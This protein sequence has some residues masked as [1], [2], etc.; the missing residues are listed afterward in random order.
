MYSNKRLV[1]SHE[2]NK[3]SYN[4]HK[5]GVFIAHLPFKKTVVHPSTSCSPGF[6]FVPPI[7]LSGIM[8]RPV[9]QS[10]VAGADVDMWLL[11]FWAWVLRYISVRHKYQCVKSRIAVLWV[12][13]REISLLLHMAHSIAQNAIHCLRTRVFVRLYLC[14]CEHVVC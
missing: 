9:S 7:S 8:W 2:I 12:L 3:F 11:V 10:V 13:C 6:F 14:V 5:I 4:A 1:K